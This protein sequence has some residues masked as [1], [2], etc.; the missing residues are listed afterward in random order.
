MLCADIET[1]TAERTQKL[2]LRVLQ[3]QVY[4]LQTALQLV[5]KKLP[6]APQTV[7]LAGSGE[8]LGRVVLKETPELVTARVV[9]LADELGPA[10][11]QAACAHALATLATEASHHGR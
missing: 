9:S 3:R 10:I 7:V 11:S 1:C 4:A 6:D 2:A 8:F 5:V